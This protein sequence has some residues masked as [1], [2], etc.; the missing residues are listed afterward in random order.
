MTETKPSF[1]VSSIVTG[2]ELS[3]AVTPSSITGCDYDASK[4]SYTIKKK[5]TGTVL[6]SGSSYSSGALNSFTGEST[7]ST[8]VTYTLT[9]TNYLGGGGTSM[10]FDVTYYVIIPK[11][12][13]T[14][15][16]KYIAGRTYNISV[17]SETRNGFGCSGTGTTTIGTF[18]G[19]AISNDWT[20]IS[21][22]ANSTNNEF[23][24]A[25]NAPSN[26]TCG[27]SW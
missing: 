8:T 14:T 16:E 15:F 17:G 9:L 4:C 24:V 2:T 22:T 3:V 12:A 20:R 5:S 27:I 6:A 25:D 26:L 13:T 7:D 11:T 23:I 19:Q 18:N 21:L 10:D 1:N